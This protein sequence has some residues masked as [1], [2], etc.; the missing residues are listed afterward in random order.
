MRFSLGKAKKEGRPEDKF[1]EK[2]GQSYSRAV[3]FRRHFAGSVPKS[4]GEGIGT[5]RAI[6]IKEI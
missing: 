6:I 4:P 5:N 1:M 3:P 2:Y